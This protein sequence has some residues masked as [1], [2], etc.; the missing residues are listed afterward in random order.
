MTD[1]CRFLSR[2]VISA[3]LAMAATLPSSAALAAPDDM[4]LLRSYLGEWQGKGTLTGADIYPM[5]CQLSLLEGNAGRVNYS[6]RCHVE[7]VNLSL[8]G[9]LAY[10]EKLRRFEAAMTTNAAFSGVAIGQKRGE[11]LVFNLNERDR[12]EGKDLT[13]TARIVL[14]RGGIEVEFYA[15]YDQT[16]ENL[17]AQVP[18]SR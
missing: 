16:G 14:D 6:G 17:R 5:R 18:F 7:G 1:S 2:L 11:T 12:A 13:I 3:C 8:N 9:S 15:V 10:I 4:A